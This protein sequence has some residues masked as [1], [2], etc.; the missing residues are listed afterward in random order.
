MMPPKAIKVAVVD[1]RLGRAC[2][3][4]VDNQRV[5]AFPHVIDATDADALNA[6][7]ATLIWP[8]GQSLTDL[9]RFAPGPALPGWDIL[10]AYRDDV[11]D[12]PWAGLPLVHTPAPSPAPSPSKIRRNLNAPTPSPQ[13]V[14]AFAERALHRLVVSPP[15]RRRLQRLWQ[16]ARHRRRKHPHEV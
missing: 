2:V 1:T 5:L 10:G 3:L 13:P 6:F 4:A 9:A 15:R 11:G 14:A 7:Y 12:D 8:P 16:R